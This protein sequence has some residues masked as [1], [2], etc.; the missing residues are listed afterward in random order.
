VV[1]WVTQTRQLKKVEEEGEGRRCGA[2]K[3]SQDE[4]AAGRSRGAQRERRKSVIQRTSC[5]RRPIFRRP[6]ASDAS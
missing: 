2:K 4:T 6:Q 1:R 5:P 3:N